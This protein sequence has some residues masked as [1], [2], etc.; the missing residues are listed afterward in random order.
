YGREAASE[1]Q[2][3]ESL[4]PITP[5]EPAK[6]LDIE[7][8]QNETKP[9]ARFNEATL[10]SAMEG[11][12]KFVDDEELREAMREKGL[13][14]PATRAAIIEGLLHDGY[15]NRQGRELIV[16]AKGTALITLLR[17]I[18]VTE[19]CSPEMTGEWESK[20]KRMAKGALKRKEFMTEIKEFTREI[21]EKA[22]HF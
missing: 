5:N 9:P 13:G 2:G 3:E 7:V 17:G 22:K 18:G 6:V 21:V 10:L 4:V 11:A 12:G 15:L 14:T 20:L 8:A 16:T 1:Q 19:L